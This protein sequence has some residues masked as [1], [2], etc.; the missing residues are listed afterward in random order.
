MN[1]KL[2]KFASDINLAIGSAE[3]TFKKKRKYRDLSDDSM[4][5]SKLS[6]R[7]NNKGPPKP[8][9]KMKLAEVDLN[10]A[11]DIE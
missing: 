4:E 9:K 7:S 11:M 2:A 1:E 10:V 5:E 3:T 6:P 8:E